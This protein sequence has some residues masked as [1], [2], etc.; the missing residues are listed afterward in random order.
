MG[1]TGLTWYSLRSTF[2]LDFIIEELLCCPS[3]VHNYLTRTKTLSKWVLRSH[4]WFKL[5]GLSQIYFGLIEAKSQRSFVPWNGRI[6]K[7]DSW[8]WITVLP[9]LYYLCA[10]DV[11]TGGRPQGWLYPPPLTVCSN[12]VYADISNHHQMQQ[13]ESCLKSFLSLGSFEVPSWPKYEPIL[14]TQTFLDA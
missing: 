8:F 14:L 5:F 4:F 3:K 1:N 11:G 7:W 13:Y 10:G 12:G 2:L 6:S 9:T